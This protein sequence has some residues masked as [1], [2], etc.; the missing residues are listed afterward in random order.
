M[1]HGVG[2]LPALRQ[3]FYKSRIGIRICAADAMVQVRHV[4][5]EIPRPGKAA[6]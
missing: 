5:M 1:A 3:G 4:Q 2:K 6:Q